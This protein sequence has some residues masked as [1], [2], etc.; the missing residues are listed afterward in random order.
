MKKSVLLTF[1]LSFLL[2]CGCRSIS[3]DSSETSENPAVQKFLEYL[4]STNTT[5]FIIQKDNQIILEKYWG[6]GKSKAGNIASAGK[7][8]CSVLVGIAVDQGY[9]KLEDSISAYIGNGFSDMSAAAEDTITVGSLLSMTSG[10]DDLLKMSFEP[11]AGWAY[12]DAW[13]LLFNVLEAATKK[14]INSYAKAVLFDKIGM[15]D[16]Y[17]KASK[18]Q[19]FIFRGKNKPAYKDWRPYQVYCTT[20]DMI[21][22]G[23]LIL[24]QGGWDGEQI[25]SKDYLEKALQP[26][27]SYNPAYGYLF[28]L[29]EST[30]GLGP[31]GDAPLNTTIIPSA[32]QDLV[33]ALGYG[34]KKIYI[35]PSMN[36]VIAR[37]GGAATDQQYAFTTFDNELWAQLNLLFESL[38][39]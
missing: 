22:F 28:W 20:Q 24:Q 25:V 17:Y 18:I 14:D 27:S 4:D 16:S 38:F 23:Q 39:K 35:I 30:N 13:N 19:L 31:M 36:M 2:S 1:V 34:D 8:I 15:K 6:T 26:S 37:S 5:G 10:L 21:K 32:P 3:A 7:S 33:A 11:N 12:S 29:N 9:L